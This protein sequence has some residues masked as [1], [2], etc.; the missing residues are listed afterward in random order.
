MQAALCDICHVR[1]S[2]VRVRVSRNGRE[3]LMNLCDADYR[4]MSASSRRSPFESLFGSDLFAD[5]FGEDFPELGGLGDTGFGTGGGGDGGRARRR[6]R[7]RESANLLDSFSDQAKEIL[8]QAANRAAETGKREVDT[9]DLLYMLSD[10]EVVQTILN[11]F[12]LS[13]KELKDHIES[14]AD[15]DRKRE[16]PKTEEI[17]ISPRVKSALQLAVAAS[18]DL[19]HSYVGPEHLLIGLAEEDDGLAS[20]ILRK[21][22]LTPQALRQQTVKVVGKGAEE[23]RVQQPTNT[24]QLD[25]FSRDLTAMARKGKLDP[26]IGRAQEIETMIEVLARRKKN[27]PVL[28]GEPGVGKTA[29]VEGLGQ[30]IANGEVPEVLRN[31]RLVELNVNSMV[32]GSKY[33]GEFEERVKNVLDEIVQHSDALI[34]FIDELHTIVGAGQSGEGGLDVANVFKPALARGELHLIGATTLNEYQKHIEKDA[35]LERRFQPLFVS[36]PTIDQ[37]ITILRGLRDSFEAHHKVI[38]TD[39]AIVAAAE[40]SERYITNRYLP[41]KAIDLIDQACARVRIGSTSRPA[42][43]QEL[44]AEIKQH[45]REQDYARSHKQFDKAK[46]LD[47]ETKSK[48][49]EMEQLLQKWKGRVGT[50]SQEVKIEHVAEIV[51]KITGIPITE[52]TAEERDKLIAMEKRLH[53]RVIGQDEAIVAVSD[54]VRLA[55]AGLRE[56]D[57]PI[58][59]FLFLG[60]TG[61]GKTELAK[62]LAEV[63][64]GDEDAM[65]RIDMSEYTE[66]HTVARLIGAPPGYVGYEEGGQ[67]TERIRRRP[68]AVI[69]L[70]EIEKAHPEV[71]NV[72]LQVFDDGRLTDGK[73]R[74]VDFTNTI[75]ICTSNV[76]AEMIRENLHQQRSYDELKSDVMS[77]LNHQFRPEFLNRIDEIIVFHALTK[78]EIR[79]IVQ[80]QLERVRKTA[81]AQG[82]YLTFDDSLID[83]LAEVGFIPEFGARELKRKIRT[84]METKLAAAMLKRE[85]TEGDS[86][87]IHYDADKDTVVI[88][89]AKPAEREAATAKR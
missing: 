44:E 2:T 65:V 23:G 15:K 89:K 26:V 87:N 78:E 68:H 66:R 62:A 55:R 57:R 29:I 25:K 61:V 31:K 67:L 77:L 39:E 1:P 30:R 21:Y 51:S 72:L 47:E 7:E 75:I 37:T 18:Q 33:R 84:Q 69:L 9:E 63:V 10:N 74:V 70:D 49:N 82:L 81:R 20:Q 80:L 79:E 4:R 27:N 45:K 16:E 83:H 54:A 35:A 8:Q 36:E 64:F 86:V 58:A 28:I 34:V 48:E 71:H 17:G 56:G 14:A 52:L 53:E 88:E 6:Q 19:G 22:G 40:L 5:F 59:T 24:P 42:E 43:I 12:K 11:Q 76:G 60:P 32:A 50:G 38:V 41:D 3:E 85:I 73:G 46:K 13:P